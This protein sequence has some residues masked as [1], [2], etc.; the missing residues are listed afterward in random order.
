MRDG[1][2]H[3]HSAVWLAHTHMHTH[4]H[5]RTQAH[6]RTHTRA[7]TRTRTHAHTHTHTHAL[8]RMYVQGNTCVGK[9][10]FDLVDVLHTWRAEGEQQAACSVVRR[11]ERLRL[12]PR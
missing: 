10:I 3:V 2:L 7:H 6:T 5:M 9:S 4:A 12:S 8:A 11:G 1:P